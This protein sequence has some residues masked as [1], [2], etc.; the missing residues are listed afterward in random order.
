MIKKLSCLCAVAAVLFVFA[1]ANVANAQEAAQPA[2]CPC[3][4][5]PA[6][7]QFTPACPPVWARACPP[8]VSY[9][10]GPFGG[11]RTVVHAPVYRA[12]VVVVPRPVRAP[13]V[14]V[15]QPTWY[16]TWW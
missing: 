7:C 8:V 11:I 9:R 14:W 15:P 3:V 5:A 2:G 13:V 4:A 6:P 1:T 10:I 16:G 12:P